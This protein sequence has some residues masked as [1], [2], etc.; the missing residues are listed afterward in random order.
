MIIRSPKL[1]EGYS[2]HSLDNQQTDGP[3]P[4]ILGGRRAN[5]IGDF[6]SWIGSVSSSISQFFFLSPSNS[7]HRL[8]GTA[9]ARNDMRPMVR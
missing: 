9:P 8:K 4:K 2:N 5:L 1:A 3:L 6:S 7:T